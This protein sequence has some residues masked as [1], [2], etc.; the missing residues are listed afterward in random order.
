MANNE[1]YERIA[2]VTGANK[3]IGFEIVRQLAAA[4]VTVVLTARDER[5]GVE[6]T[7]KIHS[8]GLS[9]V[10]FHQ[11]DVTDIN[12]IT[13]LVHFIKA[14]FGRL[15]ILV[16]NAGASGM[17]VDDEGLRALNIDAA[18]WKSGKAAS[19]VQGVM[20]TT[21]EKAEECFNTNYYGAEEVAEALLP[22]LKLSTTGARIV[23]I[24]SLRGELW[25]IPNDQIRSKFTNIENLT[26]AE[27]HEI[28]QK[29]LQD[30]KQETLIEN[31]WP[32]MLPAY[33]ISKT[34]LNAYTRLLARKYP[35]MYI[36]CV[37][38]GY[39][40]TDLAW[41]TGPMSPEDGAKAPVRLALSPEGGPTGCYFDQMKVASF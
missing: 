18:T 13:S 2:V 16:N 38:P 34:A 25:R 24:S 3:G 14:K 32:L 8:L 5:R 12:S 9:N 1:K 28:L 35:E 36:N 10:V 17:E 40:D 6:A 31:G 27:I 39:V 19:L 29:F 41:H 37:H 11:M 23:N 22:L 15:D 21:Y 7:S 26:E 20:K 33:G 30:V 4:G